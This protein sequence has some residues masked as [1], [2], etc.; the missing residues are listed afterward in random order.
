MWVTEDVSGRKVVEQGAQRQEREEMLQGVKG[1]ES[2]H[3]MYP[4]NQYI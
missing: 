2:Q 4:R 1:S 3:V